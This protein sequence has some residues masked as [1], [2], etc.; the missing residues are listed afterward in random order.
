MQR[1]L[2]SW[3]GALN[4]RPAANIGRPSDAVEEGEYEGPVTP[5]RRVLRQNVVG[6]IAKGE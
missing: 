3:M 4:C 1:V 2:R 5:E 6:H